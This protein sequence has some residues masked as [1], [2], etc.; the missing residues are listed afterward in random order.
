MTKGKRIGE[1]LGVHEG[2]HRQKTFFFTNSFIATT[3][4]I[5]TTFI[6]HPL[7]LF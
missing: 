1:E 6:S 4:F 5:P 2:K 3:S 7:L